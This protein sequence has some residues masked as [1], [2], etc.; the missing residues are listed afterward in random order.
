MFT[1]IQTARREAARVV[2]EEYLETKKR[3]ARMMPDYEARR[4]VVLTKKGEE[5]AK[6]NDA[7]S[8][9]I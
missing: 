9:K 7:A 1:A 2:H 6:K 3:L 8:G 5:Y 4:A